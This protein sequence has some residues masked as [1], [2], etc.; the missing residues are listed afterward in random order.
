M[1]L[2]HLFDKY[3]AKYKSLKLIRQNI[4]E[5]SLLDSVNKELE[6][7]LSKEQLTL[8]SNAPKILADLI[9]GSD[10]PYVY[11]KIGVTIDHYLP[12]MKVVSQAWNQ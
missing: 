12:G 4:K 2:K 11:D 5:T 6:D 1:S 8:L 9:D 7:Y 3:F 10:T